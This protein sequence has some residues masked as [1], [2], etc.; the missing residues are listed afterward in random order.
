MSN[1]DE[2][3]WDGSGTKAYEAFER[4]FEEWERRNWRA[5][6]SANLTFPF[7]VS[8]EEDE[9]DAYFQVGADKAPFRLGHTMEILGLEEEDNLYGIIVKATEKGQVGEVPLCDL[10]VMPKTDG[11]YWPVREYVVWFAN[12]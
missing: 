1:E 9:D 8:R 6:L 2:H 11:N 10:E 12:R 4:K 7:K 3:L 5:W